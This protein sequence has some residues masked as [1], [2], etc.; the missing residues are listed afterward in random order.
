MI[1]VLA[2]D[3][4]VHLGWAVVRQGLGN[5]RPAYEAGGEIPGTLEAIVELYDEFIEPFDYLDHK[6]VIAIEHV[7]GKAHKVRKGGREVDIS[8]ALQASA[9]VAGIARG[10]AHRR[11]RVFGV[12]MLAAKVWRAALTGSGQASDANIAAGL[13][14]M[15]GGMPTLSNKH[16]RDAMGLGWHVA[17][18]R[19]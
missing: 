10:L 12:V 7:V 19:S 16:Q 6:L 2:L 13:K 18:R 17:M 15:L 9:H 14:V 5:C 3:P 8:D 11:E 1:R 4:G